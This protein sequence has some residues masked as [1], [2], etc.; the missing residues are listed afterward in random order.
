[1]KIH[2][3][4]IVK[5]IPGAVRRP[6]PSISFE[7]WELQIKPVRAH[8]EEFFK[9]A[10]V[11]DIILWPSVRDYEKYYDKMLADWKPAEEVIEELGF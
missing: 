2:V 6:S 10:K 4:Y 11:D 3:G 7:A 1:M 8:F 9:L 5:W